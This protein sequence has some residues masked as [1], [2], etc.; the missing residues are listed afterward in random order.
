MSN[1]AGEIHASGSARVQIGDNHYYPAPADPQTT[2]SRTGAKSDDFSITFGISNVV[3]IDN[4]VTREDELARM[5]EKLSG[6]DI[7]RRTII[8]QGLGGIGKTQLTVDFIKVAK[9][10]LQEYLL[11]HY[12]SRS[13]A[14]ESLDKV[15]EATLAWLSLRENTKWLQISFNHVKKRNQ[16]LANL[17]RLWA[18]LDNQ[19]VWCSR[20]LYVDQGK[21]NKAEKIYKRALDGFE[22]VSDYNHIS[23]LETDN[24]LGALYA[25]QGALYANQGKFD[26]AE[27]MY[28]RALGEV[29]KMYKRA[30]DGKEK[31]YGYDH[32]STL[33]TVGN[34]GNLYAFQ[35]RLD[36]AEK[37]YKRALDG[38]EK[39]YGYD[40][41]ST[42]DTVNN[43]GALYANQGKLDDAEKIYKRALVGKEKV[44]SYDHTSTLDTVYNLG[45]LYADQGK[46][47]EAE[48]M[49]RRVRLAYHGLPSLSGNE[50]ERLEH[51]TASFEPCNGIAFTLLAFGTTS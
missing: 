8:L 30:L 17:L 21:L 48:K 2:G 22:K 13:D 23:T 14:M 33:D 41:I 36:K 45:K 44:Y 6:L 9:R 1:T 3:A 26:E 10:I 32:I 43:L 29:E 35:G 27:K 38:K 7:R 46:L 42:L 11:A 37:M 40:H 51:L 28:K 18:Y 19:D 4:F 5:H 34:F 15:A 39:V 25:N 12:L 47:D 16:L 20:A 49:H 24:N 50:F 31:V